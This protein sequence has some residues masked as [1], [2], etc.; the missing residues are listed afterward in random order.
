MSN[1]ESENP[2]SLEDP[3]TTT[4]SNRS[5]TVVEMSGSTGTAAASVIDQKE[6]E[7]SPPADD[8]ADESAD[9]SPLEQK[10]SRKLG[11]VLL[12]VLLI[13]VTINVLQAQQRQRAAVQAGEIELA[14]DR[15]MQRIDA[16]TIRANAAEGTISE[17]D[18]NVDNVQERIADL[19]SALSKLSEATT[20]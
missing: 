3:T 16:E 7:A 9:N 15:A 20:R 11:I 13:S 12:V 17:I 8:S 14:L 6:G 2:E 1:L 4:A 5:A 18:R 19:Q 10:R